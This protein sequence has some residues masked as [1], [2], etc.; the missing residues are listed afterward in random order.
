MIYQTLHRKLKIEQHKLHQN[1]GWN[2]VLK[3]V[4]RS[5]PKQTYICIRVIYSDLVLLISLSFG[6][7]FSIFEWVDF[8]RSFPCMFCRSLFVLL[9]FFF[10]PLYCLSFNLWFWLPLWYLHLSLVSLSVDK[11][12]RESKKKHNITTYLFGLTRT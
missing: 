8:A 5:D 1:Q 12:D 7:F 11:H 6:S 10:W 4:H 3:Y 2:Q 9:S